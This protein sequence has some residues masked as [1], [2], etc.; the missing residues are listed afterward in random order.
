MTG[1][2]G[3]NIVHEGHSR[4]PRKAF[5]CHVFMRIYES[6]TCGERGVVD[7]I[8]SALPGCRHDETIGEAARGM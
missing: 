6:S 2:N 3:C 8:G 4:H 1:A 7:G 5:D